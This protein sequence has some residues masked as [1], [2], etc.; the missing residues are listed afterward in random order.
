MAGLGGGARLGQFEAG[1][2]VPD[3]QHHSSTV[4][5]EQHL[6]PA[7]VRVL[8]HVREG[9]ERHPIEDRASLRRRLV[10][11]AVHHPP[12]E[13]V[14]CEGVGEEQLEGCAQA[15]FVERGRPQLEEEPAEAPVRLDQGGAC[16]EHGLALGRVLERRRQRVHVQAGRRHRLGGVVVDVHG[17][18]PARLLL[19]RHEFGHQPRLRLLALLDLDGGGIERVGHIGE[20]TESSRDRGAGGEVAGAK[21][22]SRL[23]YRGAPASQQ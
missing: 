14:V 13:A 12:V 22:S 17:D 23:N 2:V 11:E 4:A 20:L 5:L 16:L 15:R 1:A 18:S 7:G 6:D 8:S 21:A 19:G 10:V 9:L 3:A